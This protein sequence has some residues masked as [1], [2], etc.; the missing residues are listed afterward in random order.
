MSP[1]IVS[2]L[3]NV[4]TGFGV[5]SILAYI[6]LLIVREG[7]KDVKEMQNIL[8]ELVKKNTKA[9]TINTEVTRQAADV[10]KEL[11]AKVTE[12]LIRNTRKS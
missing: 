5:A 2:A 11:V 9:S 4:G 1:D 6:I 8:I 3:A 7:R 10:N 12:V